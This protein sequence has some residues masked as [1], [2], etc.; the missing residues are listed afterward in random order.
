MN[1]EIRRRLKWVRLLSEQGDSGRVCRRCGISRPTLRKW[2][3]RYEALGETGLA[4]LSRRPHWSPSRKLTDTDRT[5]FLALREQGNGARRI[6]SELRLPAERELSLATIHKVLTAAKVKP[7][8][9]PKRPTL[10]K[11]Y[12]RPIPSDRVQMDTMKITPGVY[13]YTAVDDCSRFRV[14]GVY[15]RRTA[16]N[17]LLLLNRVIEEMPFP[18]RRMQTDRGGEFL[19]E[20]VQRRLRQEFI[21]FRPIPPRLPHLN[22][23]V[24]RSQLTDLVEFWARQSPQD[25]EIDARIVEWQFDYNWRCSH[26]G[27]GGNTPADRIATSGDQVPLREE[28]AQAYDESR[29]RFRYR[30]WKVDQAMAALFRPLVRPTV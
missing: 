30:D 12:S 4:S 26:G 23:K 21:K 27:L 17:T 15:P 22:G 1:E 8:V 18:I 5:A 2:V 3:R 29:E 28:V 13:Q 19:A 9:K 20:S 16:R 7:L 24:E 11:R 14:L 10:P 25:A 6:Q